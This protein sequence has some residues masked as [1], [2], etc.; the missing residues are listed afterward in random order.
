MLTLGDCQNDLGLLRIAS[1]CGTSP[2]FIDLINAATRQ[3]LRRGDWVGTVVPIY[4]CVTNGCVVWPRYVQTVRKLSFCRNPVKVQ[5]P[6][7]TYMEGVHNSCDGWAWGGTSGTWMSDWGGHIRQQGKTSVFQDIQ[8]DGRLVRAYARCPGDLG[9]TLTI[10]GTDNNGQILQTQNGDGSFSTGAILTLQSPFA[11][12]SQ[13]VRSIDY[14][15]KD[16]TQC[17]VDLFAYNASALLLEPLATYDPTETRPSF[18]RTSVNIPSGCVVS[19]G[20]CQQGV[21]ALVKL[22]F[23]PAQAPT[24]LVLIDNLDAL[25]L[26]VQSIKFREAGDRNGAKEYEN[27]AIHELN[28][29]LE[30]MSPDD[31]FAAIDSTF[32]GI[33]F[34]Q[35][36]F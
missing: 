3:A 2:D 18:E 34:S 4:V 16:P 17:P 28:R 8:G 35:Q 5:N 32:G 20:G 14:V 13:Y 21:A 24:D 23:I 6:W 22:K 26:L 12:T 31:Q 29:Q 15:L 19:G 27:D 11:S 25:K 33:T 9:Q 7:Y 10:F 36:C 1:Y 30:E